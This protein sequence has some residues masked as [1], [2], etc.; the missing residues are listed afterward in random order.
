MEKHLVLLPVTI[1]IGLRFT[2]I[3]QQRIGIVYAHDGVRIGEVALVPN[4]QAAEDI[5]LQIAGMN[6]EGKQFAIGADEGDN[7][8]FAF[9]SIAGCL[10]IQEMLKMRTNGLEMPITFYKN[11][12]PIMQKIYSI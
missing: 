11:L 9:A 10:H 2:K 4:C 12:R 7:G 6:V 1:Y 3:K 5:F 8:R